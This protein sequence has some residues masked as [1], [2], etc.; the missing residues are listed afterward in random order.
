MSRELPYFISRNCRISRR[1]PIWH[2]CFFFPNML[3]NAFTQTSKM[4]PHFFFTFCVMV[5]PPQGTLDKGYHGNFGNSWSENLLKAGTPS[6]CPSRPHLWSRPWLGQ[7]NS[8]QQR[9]K[10]QCHANHL[11]K[12]SG[13]PLARWLSAK[14]LYAFGNPENAQALLG[15][16]CSAPAMNATAFHHPFQP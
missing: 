4:H 2:L 9:W 5:P 16:A 6:V 11:P 1:Q 13:D 15:T 10:E 8:S 14:A 3:G 7:E 12:E